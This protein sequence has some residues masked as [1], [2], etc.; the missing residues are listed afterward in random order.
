MW[1]IVVVVAIVGSSMFFTGR[2]LVRWV[3]VDKG[4]CSGCSRRKQTE[5]KDTKQSKHT[6]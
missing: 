5:C 1:E 2:M 3:K 4:Q 6:R